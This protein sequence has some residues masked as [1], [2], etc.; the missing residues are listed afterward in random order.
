MSSTIPTPSA[1]PALPETA[2]AEGRLSGKKSALQLAEMVVAMV[3]G[4]LV[5][6]PV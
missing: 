6:H 2:H 4:M 1:A 3:V 5:L